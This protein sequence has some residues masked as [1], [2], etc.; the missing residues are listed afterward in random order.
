MA[1][2]SLDSWLTL[3]L[4]IPA[5]KP[6]QPEELSSVD[7]LAEWQFLKVGQPLATFAGPSPV[8]VGI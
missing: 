4:R 7:L 5:L 2:S 6:E 3:V 8:V 1:G